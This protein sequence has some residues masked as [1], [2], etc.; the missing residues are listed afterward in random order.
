MNVLQLSELPHRYCLTLNSLR[1]RRRRQGGGEGGKGEDDDPQAGA[2]GGSPAREPRDIQHPGYEHF[3]SIV[4]IL[5]THG[6][7]STYRFLKE[8]NK[9]ER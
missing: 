6:A 5:Q 9:K 1:S 7:Y 2:G 8:K 4:N 3:S